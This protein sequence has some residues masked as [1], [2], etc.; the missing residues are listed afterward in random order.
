MQTG[1]SGCLRQGLASLPSSNSTTS[2]K[3]ALI[4]HQFGTNRVLYKRVQSLG[5]KPAK[6]RF[7]RLNVSATKDLP[8]P[9]ILDRDF[10][11]EGSR[12]YKRTV[13]TRVQP[14]S[15]RGC[16]KSSPRPS[17]CWLAGFHLQQLG[18]AQEHQALCQAL[19]HHCWGGDACCSFTSSLMQFKLS[20]TYHVNCRVVFSEACYSLS[21]Q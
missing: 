19:I 18:C 9:V 10:D 4:R 8:L 16:R 11:K 2:G 15:H 1:Y 3:N 5:S 12:V 21:L 13:R 14:H 20:L 17:S 7:S 6:Q